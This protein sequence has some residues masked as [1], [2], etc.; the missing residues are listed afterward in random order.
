MYTHIKTT[1]TA[2]NTT[3]SSHFF[4]F[5]SYKPPKIR[6]HRAIGTNNVYLYNTIIY[7]NGSKIK[8]TSFH[9][10]NTCAIISTNNAYLYNTYV[11]TKDKRIENALYILTYYSNPP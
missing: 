2:Y 6:H 11:P 4:H 10:K 8:N 5:F 7:T 1:I 3:T 9:T